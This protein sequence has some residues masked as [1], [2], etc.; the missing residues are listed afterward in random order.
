MSW[1][2][3]PA[4]YSKLAGAL[5]PAV[6]VLVVAFLVNRQLVTI[7]GIQAAATVLGVLLAPAN[8]SAGDPP[9]P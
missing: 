9:K 4:G 3:S 8:R 7:A 5:L 6:V 2:T 1:P